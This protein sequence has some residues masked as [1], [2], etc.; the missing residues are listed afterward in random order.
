[1]KFVMG[2]AIKMCGYKAY[3]FFGF[4]HNMSDGISARDSHERKLP[5]R[6]HGV[7]EYYILSCAMV[8]SGRGPERGTNVLVLSN[9]CAR[10]LCRGGGL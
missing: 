8:Y 6:C 1:M 7:A 3:T 4:E 5:R 2:K 9:E 10:Q